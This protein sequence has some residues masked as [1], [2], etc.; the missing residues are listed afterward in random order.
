MRVTPVALEQIRSA[1]VPMDLSQH[2]KCLLHSGHWQLEPGSDALFGN[3]QKNDLQGEK[4]NITFYLCSPK[5]MSKEKCFTVVDSVRISLQEKLRLDN[6]ELQPAISVSDVHCCGKYLYRTARCDDAPL[7]CNRPCL[8]LQVP[9]V[10][11]ISPLNHL[12]RDRLIQLQA[13][14]LEVE[15]CLIASFTS[16]LLVEGGDDRLFLNSNGVNKY[17]CPPCPVDPDTTLL[18]S[19]CTCSPPT[20]EGFERAS[21]VVEQLWEQPELYFDIHMESV[22]KRILEALKLN[23]GQTFCILHPS[24]SDAELLP[25]LV[26]MGRMEKLGAH[27]IVNVVSAAG[28]VGSGTAPAAAGK[29]FSSVSPTGYKVKEDTT[30]SSFP[31]S[32][33]VVQLSPRGKDGK[34][35]DFDNLAREQMRQVREKYKDAIVIFHAVDG[36]KTGLKLPSHEVIEELQDIWDKHL[37]LVL[38]A[39]QGR[40][41]LEEYQWFLDKEALILLTG[42]KFFCGPGFC[43]SV[44]FSSSIMQELESLSSIP[45]GISFY[46]TKNE[47]SESMPCLRSKL[48]SHPWNIGLLLRW[49]CALTEMERFTDIIVDSSVID[50]W[51][52][53]VRSMIENH[54]P[55]IRVLVDE[56]WLEDVMGVNSIVNLIVYKQNGEAMNLNELR[57]LHRLLSSTMDSVSC[58]IQ[59]ESIGNWICLIGQPVNLGDKSVIRLA[60]GASQIRAVYDAKCTVEDLLCDDWKIL[61]KLQFLTEHFHE[62]V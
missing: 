33:H 9:V 47:V 60:L 13:L 32:I 43:G 20:K 34:P 37:V 30:I 15:N 40:S 26:A 44:L 51:S 2:L 23:D 59:E 12:D 18:R 48:P 53:G 1:K 27:H 4:G 62:I 38:D 28:E 50:Q 21:T 54:F 41:D 46:I 11:V 58:S 61:K 22:R 45:D 35:V 55:F 57:V 17:F 14:L 29:H 42:S 25:L 7:G 49:E 36:S 19:S 16:Q 52:Y 39:C 8:I 24:G 3:I 6:H 31:S 5:V 56:D 10:N